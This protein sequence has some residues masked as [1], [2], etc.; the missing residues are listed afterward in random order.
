MNQSP[1]QTK[2]ENI[3]EKVSTSLS[4]KLAT[5]TLNKNAKPEDLGSAWKADRC[6]NDISPITSDGPRESSMEQVPTGNQTP[7]DPV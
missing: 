4:N 3:D 6:L 2:L 1:K 5:E 7:T